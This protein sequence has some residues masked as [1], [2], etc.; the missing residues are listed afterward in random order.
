MG[1]DRQ[2]AVSL[3]DFY[4]SKL[5]YLCDSII[6]FTPFIRFIFYLESSIKQHLINNSLKALLDP[7]LF[8]SGSWNSFLTHSQSHCNNPPTH[9]HTLALSYTHHNA[10]SFC[11]AYV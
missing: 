1:R 3:K 8:P 7:P 10:I 2:S 11:L 4:Y 6:F 9:T 5:A